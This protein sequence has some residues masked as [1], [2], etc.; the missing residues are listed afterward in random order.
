MMKRILFLLAAAI[1]ATVSLGSVEMVAAQDGWSVGDTSSFYFFDFSF[2]T[3]YRKSPMTLRGMGE[4]CYVWTQDSLWARGR[5]VD[6]TGVVTDSIVHPD[7]IRIDMEDVEA[8]VEA[9]NERTPPAD[10]TAEGLLNDRRGIYDKVT[11]LYGEPPDIDG[12]PRIYILIIDCTERYG[13]AAMPGY[14]DPAN[15]LTPIENPGSNYHE[16]IYID[17]DP[18]DPSSELGL[19]S[20]AQQFTHLIQYKNDRHEDCWI[21]D[22]LT[23]F[24]QFVCGYKVANEGGIFSRNFLKV[25]LQSIMTNCR[26]Q[27]EEQD[28]VK[29]TMFMQYIF[30]QYGIE[31][32]QTLATDTD[33]S[34]SEA[35][36]EALAKHGYSDVDFDSLFLDEQLAWFFDTPDSLGNP[37]YDRKYFFKYYE[38]GAMLDAK[39]YTTWCKLDNPPYFYPGNQW[40]MD[41]IL[42]N[43]PAPCLGDTIVFNGDLGHDFRVMA[44]K[45]NLEW[46]MAFDAEK[47]VSLEF[48]TLDERNRGFLDVSGYGDD[49][50]MVYIA[51]LH[52]AAK[53]GNQTSR[54]RFV[55]DNDLTPPDSLHVAVIQNPLADRYFKI[56]IASNESLFVDDYQDQRPL[57][58]MVRGSE[59]D[60]LTD[61]ERFTIIAGD[62]ST[63]W[64]NTVVYLQ[65]FAFTG[66]GSF[67]IKVS[68][69]DMAGNF[70]PSDE[71]DGV[72]KVVGAAKG[73]TLVTDDERISLTVPPGA[74]SRETYLTLLPVTSFF[75]ALSHTEGKLPAAL[76]YPLPKLES[77]EAVGS[78]VQFGPAGKGLSRK[79]ELRMRYTDAE[80]KDR[81]EQSLCIHRLEGSEWVPVESTLHPDLN[82]ISAWVDQLGRFQICA[83]RSV[84]TARIP[85]TYA[86]FQN[87]PNPFNPATE[88][89]Y[90][91][92]SNREGGTVSV[93]LRV[94]NVLGQNVR[95]LVDGLQDPGEYTVIWDGKDNSGRMQPSGIYFYRMQAGQ[96]E[97]TR[98]MILLK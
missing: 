38:S 67:Q 41:W 89:R 61:I 47:F 97:S 95:T 74:F 90:H 11:D 37:W 79:A 64:E 10:S 91:L 2:F 3:A 25:F 9:F 32:I 4:H 14:F 76:G 77:N 5:Y 85:E 39:T 65:D 63:R 78:A 50:T 70:A 56:Y 52:M 21:T 22:G 92:P 36:T 15:Q 55:I 80:L 88:I 87:Y 35:V 86:L 13:Y 16:L 72:V 30:E 51:V 42:V 53:D 17:C 62:S 73:A 20:I 94:Y 19:G 44:V 40:S 60:T 34:G 29:T 48:I 26:E 49:Y 54:T 12:D 84:Q 6:T 33:K 57:L 98:R 58:E 75:D 45:A 66:E 59:R 43:P 7:S 8:I 83:G 18:F 23:Y 68:G 82:E 69:W 96:F 46:Q 93:A 71:I 1:T 28:K 27:P 24:S 81:D 31:V